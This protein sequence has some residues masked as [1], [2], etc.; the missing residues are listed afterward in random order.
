MMPAAAAPVKSEIITFQIG[1][2]AVFFS[3]KLAKGSPPAM[4]RFTF[5]DAK[6]AVRLAP[7]AP[8]GVVKQTL[9]K[10]RKGNGIAV[11]QGAVSAVVE[12]GGVEKD[13]PC[14]IEHFYFSDKEEGKD[15]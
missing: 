8:S 10:Y 11:P 6:G 2:R 9:T 5:K 7:L 14:T 1:T 15:K 4:V 3:L 13:A 12:V